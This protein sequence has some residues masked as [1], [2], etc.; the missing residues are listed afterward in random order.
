[1][2]DI[3]AILE[4]ELEVGGRALLDKIDR[5]IYG[6]IVSPLNNDFRAIYTLQMNISVGVA[7]SMLLK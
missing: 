1:V 3:G 6:A 4:N 2:F 5:D 7:V